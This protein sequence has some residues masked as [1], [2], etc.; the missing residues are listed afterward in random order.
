MSIKFNMHSDNEEKMRNLLL[1]Q[2]YPLWTDVKYKVYV[3]F[4]FKIGD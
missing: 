1:Q 3:E 2:N 4:P